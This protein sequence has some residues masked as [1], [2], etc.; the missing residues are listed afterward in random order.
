MQ[1]LAN[2]FQLI[3]NLLHFKDT[4]CNVQS[5]KFYCFLQIFTYFEWVTCTSEGTIHIGLG[6]TYG[7]IQASYF[8][9]TFLLISAKQ[10]L[11]IFCTVTTA[12][13][14]KIKRDG[15]RLACMQSRPLSYWKWLWSITLLSAKYENG[16]PGLLIGRRRASGKNGKDFYIQCFNN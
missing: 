12:W 11:A 2:P 9:G 15:T 13:L 10:C 3:F 6:A 14:C 4:I 5:D 7:A 16:D 8:S 1:W